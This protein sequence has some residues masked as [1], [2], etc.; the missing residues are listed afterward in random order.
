MSPRHCVES[1]GHEPPPSGRNANAF[2]PHAGRLQ[3][4][5]HALRR[6][7]RSVELRR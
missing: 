7:F 2:L 5:P 3:P 6:T 4:D 1:T